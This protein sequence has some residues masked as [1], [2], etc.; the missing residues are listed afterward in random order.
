MALLWVQLSTCFSVKHN[1]HPVSQLDF[2]FNIHHLNLEQLLATTI[3]I[4]PSQLIHEG[5]Q[6]YHVQCDSIVITHYMKKCC[7]KEPASKLR[8][9]AALV[10]LDIYKQTG[11]SHQ[12]GGWKVSPHIW[13]GTFRKTK[14]PLWGTAWNVHV[15]TNAK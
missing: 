7:G 6:K 10:G 1:I 2:T 3:R 11:L 13:L 8:L 5:T 15:G 12:V 14:F 4:L 9:R